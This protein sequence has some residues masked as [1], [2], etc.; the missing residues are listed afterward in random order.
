MTTSAAEALRDGVLRDDRAAVDKAISL[1]VAFGD[2]ASTGIGVSELARRAQLSKSTAHRVLGMLE[3]NGVV[4]RAGTGYRLGARL[5]ELGQAVYPRRHEALRDRLLPHLTDLY[6]LT[7]QTVHLAMLHGPDVVF[8]A[9][10]Y[11]H[12][13]VLAPSRIGGRLPAHCT[14]VGKVLLAYDAEAAAQAVAVPLRQLTGSTITTSDDLLA[15]LARIREVGVSF[16]HGESWSGLSCVAAPV[17]GPGRRVVAAL[18]VAGQ[19]GRIDLDRANVEVRRVSAAAS[20]VLAK[21]A[22]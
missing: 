5:H 11:G 17:F 12:H 6:E 8:P 18:S 20:Q 14:G 3:R 21:A 15:E 1:L 2:Q 7:R 22:A 13:S 4:E 16:D 19:T 9:K 10:L